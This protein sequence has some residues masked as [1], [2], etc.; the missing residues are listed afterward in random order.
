MREA[1]T[2]HALSITYTSSD[3]PHLTRDKQEKR[4]RHKAAETPSLPSSPITRSH[5]PLRIFTANLL[6]ASQSHLLLSVF[7]FSPPQ[8]RLL[9]GT[10]CQPF[11]IHSLSW[12]VGSK[13]A[14][15]KHGGMLL[16]TNHAAHGY[17]VLFEA[18]SFAWRHE[19]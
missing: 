14:G 17:S 4:L 10:G 7:P 8:L 3:Q 5:P 16:A 13:S 2:N 19:V 15:E 6:P 11:T 18:F 12:R 9:T 1:N